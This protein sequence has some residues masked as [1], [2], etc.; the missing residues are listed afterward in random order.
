MLRRNMAAVRG[1]VLAFGAAALGA[2]L[3]AGLGG[4]GAPSQAAWTARV[5]LVLVCA[6][7][8]SVVSLAKWR[9]N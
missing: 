1:P 9:T 2:S 4:P 5:A 8:L 3:V 6:G 7:L